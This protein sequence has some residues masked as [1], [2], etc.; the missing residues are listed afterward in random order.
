M[1][2]TTIALRGDQT[3]VDLVDAAGNRVT[4]VDLCYCTGDDML[5]L[6]FYTEPNGTKRTT[7]LD[8]EGEYHWT[9]TA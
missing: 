1:T 9:V 3:R 4:G 7:L 2:T 6:V 5:V 8:P